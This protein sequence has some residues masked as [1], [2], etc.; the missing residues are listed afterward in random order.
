MKVF[1]KY[2]LKELKFPILL[3]ISIF[4]FIFLIEII[5][6]MMES[7]IVNSV[8]IFD[9]MRMLSFYLPAI[10]VQTI[11]MGVFLGIMITFSK[12]TKNSETLALTSMGISLKRMLRPI[13]LFT[14]LITLFIFFLQ[15]KIVPKSFEKLQQLTH[16][17][18]TENPIFQMKEKIFMDDMEEFS[19]YVNEKDKTTGFAKGVLIFQ[20]EKKGVY[21]LILLGKKALWENNAMILKESEFFKFKNEGDLELK[22]KFSEKTIPLSS[23]GNNFK[24]KMKDIEMMEISKLFKEYK[25]NTVNK[26]KYL[27]EINK[28]IAIPI[29]TIIL[30][31]LGVLFASGHHRTGKGTNFPLSLFVIFSYIITL[32]LG[33]VVA[34]KGQLNVY[35][36]IWSPNIVLL[37]LTYYLYLKKSRVM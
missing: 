22:G 27:V 29:S 3:G 26:I 30:G 18:A 36:A 23:Y 2:I 1:E 9:M 13:I 25:K 16:K 19:I 34:L 4:T 15:E 20:Q 24:I 31:V 10:L 14:F 12:F 33:M 37:I 32:N 21:P 8:S 17:I 7:I 28:K 11:P 6:T 5:V 35:I